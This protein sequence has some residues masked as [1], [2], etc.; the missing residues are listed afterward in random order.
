MAAIEIS[1]VY[2]LSLEYALPDPCASRL[3]KDF[4]ADK[5]PD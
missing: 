1:E 3:D 5:T 2:I 4:E